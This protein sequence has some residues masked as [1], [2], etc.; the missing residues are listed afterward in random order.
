MLGYAFNRDK[1]IHFVTP[2]GPLEK[3][4]IEHLSQEVDPYIETQGSL[5]GLLIA[6][7]MDSGWKSFAALISPLRFVKNHHRKIKRIAAVSESGLRSILPRFATTICSRCN[8]TF[9]LW[10]EGA[11]TGVA[12]PT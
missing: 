4:D 6:A 9:R 7:Q 11:G 8:Q 5:S 3:A 10:K 2:E 1:G 12:Q